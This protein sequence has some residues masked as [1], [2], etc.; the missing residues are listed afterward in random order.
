MAKSNNRYITIMKAGGLSLAAILILGGITITLQDRLHLSRFPIPV[1]IKEQLNKVKNEPIGCCLPQCGVGGK[2]ICEQSAGNWASENCD[3]ISE[4]QKGCCAPFNGMYSKAECEQKSG[5]Q[6]RTEDCFGFFTNLIGSEHT[7]LK[8]LGG[9]GDFQAKFDLH[10]CD[11][12]PYSQWSGK[13]SVLWTF[14]VGGVGSHTD[15]TY[16]DQDIKFTVSP[17]GEGSF[18][19]FPNTQGGS[20]IAHFQATDKQ[21]CVTINYGELLTLNTCSPIGQGVPVCLIE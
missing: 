20:T 14:S 5:T 13:W 11:K 1:E 9:E 2:T 7:N 16:T 19:L 6:W 8:Q 3:Q 4:C 15:N 10:N 21:M 12:T 17:S 18:E